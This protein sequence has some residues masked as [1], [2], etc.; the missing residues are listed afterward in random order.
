MNECTR[1]PAKISRRTSQKMRPGLP[2]GFSTGSLDRV[3][4]VFWSG[5]QRRF[6]PR[7]RGPEPKICS[8]L[9]VN[10]MIL[11]KSELPVVRGIGGLAMQ[12]PKFQTQC[13]HAVLDTR[14][15]GTTQQ[16]KKAGKVKDNHRLSFFHSF[17][18]LR[19]FLFYHWSSAHRLSFFWMTC[20]ST[21]PLSSPSLSNCSVFCSVLSRTLNFVS[22]HF[23]PGKSTTADRQQEQMNQQGNKFSFFLVERLMIF[24][25]SWPR[26]HASEKY[27]SLSFLQYWCIPDCLPLFSSTLTRG[28]FRQD[29]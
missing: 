26:F 12:W 14:E 23:D 3:A 2:V 27:H 4:P 9:P 18:L 24:F 17:W 19:F 1:V 7:G 21:C 11:K 28:P 29:Q 10:C 13:I 20:N 8:Q 16:G 22:S 6:D 25:I 5:G 15:G